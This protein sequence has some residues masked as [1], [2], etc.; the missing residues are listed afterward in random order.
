MRRWRRRAAVLAALGLCLALGGCGGGHVHDW[1]EATCTEPLRCL[2]CGAVQG[3]PLGHDWMPADCTQGEHCARCT[4]VQGEALGHWVEEWTQVRP[5]DCAT[6][7]RQ[8]GTCLRC[9]AE[10]TQ[11]T[12]TVD[13]T[14]DGTGTVCTVCG[15][16]LAA[17]EA[18]AEER[19]RYEE[20]CRL[21]TYEELTGQAERLYGAQV[22][23]SGRVAQTV[24][25]EDRDAVLLEADLE[26]VQPDGDS[27]GWLYVEWPEGEAL[28]QEGASVSA[29][30]ELLSPYRWQG[31]DGSWNEA[32]H[33]RAR[34]A[35]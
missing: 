5:A 9:W 35:E 1:V 18:G 22:Y 30:G 20:N 26:D 31:L 4:A 34:Y 2:D 24:P 11:E 8:A 13:H 6:P 17:L 21:Y 28:P 25:G 33:V 3:E 19:Q 23:V 7:G 16:D 15:A 27:Q 12:C 10:V 14:P 29:W 32:P